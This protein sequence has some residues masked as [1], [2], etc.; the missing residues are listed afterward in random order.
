MKILSNIKALPYHKFTSIE[1]NNPP[2]TVE[3][4]NT[5][6]FDQVMLQR[7]AAK[8]DMV[9]A[10]DLQAK[11][12]QEISGG[13]STRDLEEIKLQLASDTYQIGFEEIA[14]RMIY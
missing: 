13:T 5:K 10:Q 4:S 7:Q 3:Q 9:F 8:D 14:R 11:L 6:Q 12:M 1:K 2:I